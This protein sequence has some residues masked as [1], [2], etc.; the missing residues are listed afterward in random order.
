MHWASLAVGLCWLRGMCIVHAATTPTPSY[1]RVSPLPPAFPTTADT[2]A[3]LATASLTTTI[4]E[5]TA[6]L[7]TASLA[8]TGIAS[9]FGATIVATP[10]CIPTAHDAATTA[11]TG[12]TT[13]CS[14]TT[15]RYSTIA[16]RAIA[17]P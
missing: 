4:A 13:A 10:T 12:S 3:S 6:S 16:D 11:T 14:T 17:I 15:A 1:P 9:A 2:T 8:S 5:T 7:A